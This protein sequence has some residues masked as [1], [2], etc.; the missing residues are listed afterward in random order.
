[1]IK[2]TGKGGRITKADVLR[3]IRPQVLITL[4]PP[5]AGKTT[6][7]KHLSQHLSIPHFEYDEH[8]GEN[9]FTYHN[10]TF[11]FDAWFKN[12]NDLEKIIN[13]SRNNGFDVMF[14]HVTTKNSTCS[15]RKP[16]RKELIKETRYDIDELMSMIEQK[17]TQLFSIEYIQIQ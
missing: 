2:G 5:G 16:D 8:I 17:K 7:S 11:I 12:N 4:G 10:K 3:F 9:P 1:M 15:L 14:I 6:I 13:E